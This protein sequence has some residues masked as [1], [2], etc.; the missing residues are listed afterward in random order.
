MARKQTPSPHFFTRE[1]DGSV[2]LRHR[3][4]SEEAS[5]IEEAAGSTPLM[6][7]IHRALNEAARRDISL[8][9]QSRPATPPPEET[10]GR[11]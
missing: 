9:R 2:R 1:P 3:L 11:G 8:A 6:I 7:W 4:N 5:L 10:D